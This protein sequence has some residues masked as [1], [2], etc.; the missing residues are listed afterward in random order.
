MSSKIRKVRYPHMVFE[1]I[2]HALEYGTVDF[3]DTRVILTPVK[4]TSYADGYLN[5]CLQTGLLR[6]LGRDRG[7]KYGKFIPTHRGR[8]FYCAAQKNPDGS[9]RELLGSIPCYRFH[10]ELLLAELIMATTLRSDP[11]AREIVTHVF[12]V[13]PWFLRDRLLWIQQSVGWTDSSSYGY[14]PDRLWTLR[15]GIRRLNSLDRFI[16]YDAYKWWDKYLGFVQHTDLTRTENLCRFLAEQRQRHLYVGRQ[17]LSR[18]ALAALLFLILAEGEGLSLDTSRWPE[19]I[20][21]LRHLGIDIRRQDDRAYLFSAVRVALSASSG[22]ERPSLAGPDNDNPLRVFNHL[23]AVAEQALVANP[24]RAVLSLDLK[25][26]RQRIKEAMGQHSLFIPTELSDADDVTTPSMVE[27]WRVRPLWHQVEADFHEEVCRLCQP[28]S[29]A[30]PSAD[31]LLTRNQLTV[32]RDADLRDVVA[33]NPHLYVL[34]MLL[35]DQPQSR[36]SPTL[37]EDVWYYQGT[38]LLPALD[39]LLQDLGYTVWSERY[40]REPERRVEIARKLVGVLVEMGVAAVQFGHLEF[41]E[42]FNHALQLDCAYL[43]NQTK[44]I[45]QQLRQAVQS[46]A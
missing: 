15:T 1:I 38:E 27:I 17:L 45:R 33:H 13:L 4:N 9:V 8:Y 23:I 10:A 31:V 29:T 19:A 37:E 12:Q 21:E 16:G 36:A 24:T 41:T 18:Q 26:L 32:P 42:D 3:R 11:Q 5:L 2:D 43:A 40:E 34:L 20:G 25:V 28:Q 30:V 39:A 14:G 7:A 22:T 44:Y 6:A 46:L 35:I